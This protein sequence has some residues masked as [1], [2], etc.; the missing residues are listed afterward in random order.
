MIPA[1]VEAIRATAQPCTLLVLLP[2]VLMAIVTRG[3]W[4][5]FAA[6]CVGAVL[7]GVL[8]VA[9]VVSLSD[10]QLRVSGLVVGTAIAVVIASPYADRLAWARDER[11]Q[12]GVAGAV[13]FVSTL[14]WRPCVGREL[15]AILTASRDGVAAQVPAMAAYM[16]GTM[17][18]VLAVVLVIRAIEPSTRAAR[19][20]V[21]AAGVLGLVVAAALAVGRHDELVTTLTRWSQ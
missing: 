13:T 16:L 19:R 5:A 10:P 2:A 9:N 15:G 14:W 21:L 12:A 4:L 18:P 7:G 6:I 20:G 17:V 3:R 8:F 1:F 11:V